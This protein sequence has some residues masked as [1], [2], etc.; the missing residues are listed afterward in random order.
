VNQASLWRQADF[1][2]LWTA[3]TI[4]LFGTQ[5]TQLALPLTAVIVL[6]ASALEVGLLGV[7]QYAPWVV[8]GLPAGVW[9]DRL[10]RRAV[11]VTADLVRAAVLLAVP[12]AFAL[13]VLGLW[14][15]YPIA[16]VAGT[17]TVFFD[18]ADQSYLPSLVGRDQL[19][20]GNA[21]LQVS[22]SA[23]QLVGPG[24]GG[25]LVQLL[26][27]PAAILVDAISYV[28]SAVCLLLIRA[29]ERPAA[30]RPRPGLADVAEGLRF[31]LGHPLLRPIAITTAISNFAVGGMLQSI[32]LLYANRTLGM[33]PAAI[34]VVYVATNAGGLA[35][36]FFSRRL[37]Q[38]FGLGPT[39][40]AASALA[41]VGAL[42]LPLATP[43]LALVVLPA[44]LLLAGLGTIV[45]NVSNVTVRQSVTPDDLLGRMNATVRFLTWGAIPAGA[46]VWGLVGGAVDL[47]AAVLVAVLI[48]AC[49]TAVLV[50][51]PIRGLREAPPPAVGSAKA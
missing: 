23:A 14:M 11:L 22:Q 7:A 39:M 35:G 30:G 28:G 48:N 2:K 36:A 45:Y 41:R 40:I 20:D 43:G 1:V 4:S 31:V 13:D 37:S 29:R 50:L 15:L 47:R 46:L 25:L 6:H 10:P 26:R 42:L 16:F 34:G 21:K 49:A 27:A 17:M 19:M 12:V 24:L 51:S 38:R 8:L 5:V 3:Q 18:V 33:A 44:G 32:F 9:V